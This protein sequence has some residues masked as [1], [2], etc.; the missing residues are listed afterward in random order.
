MNTLYFSFMSNALLVA[1]LMGPLYLAIAVGM[2]ISPGH[3]K[4]MYDEIL[5]NRPMIYLSGLAAFVVG[6][7]ILYSTDL[8]GSGC[9]W[10]ISLTGWAALLQGTA[11]L[12]IP[13]QFIDWNSWVKKPRAMTII[14]CIILVFGAVM[15]YLG[16]L[17]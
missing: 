4:K 5:K 8:W 1:Q 16:Y 10:F 11:L 12:V 2:F 13:D 15:T 9:T 17:M 7:L 6:F 14:E 3:Y